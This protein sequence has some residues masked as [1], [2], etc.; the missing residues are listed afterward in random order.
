ML[1]LVRCSHKYSQAFL[2]VYL[3][4]MCLGVSMEH[5][6][7]FRC[8]EL[9]G[10]NPGKKCLEGPFSSYDDAKLHKQKARA[11]DMEHTA[12]FKASSRLSAEENME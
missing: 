5:W 8:V 1:G 2:A 10:S 12:I 7:G 6:Y 11:R 4:V 9:D 3:S